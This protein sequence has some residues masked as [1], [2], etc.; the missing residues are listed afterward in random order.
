M[1]GR[2]GACEEARACDLKALLSPDEDAPGVVRE[3]RLKVVRDA[4]LSPE[5]VRFEEQ[6]HG[7]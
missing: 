5:R 1:K 7:R 6:C 4:P 2:R 3:I